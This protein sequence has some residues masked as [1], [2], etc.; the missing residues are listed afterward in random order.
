M[1]IFDHDITKGYDDGL[2]FRGFSNFTLTPG[3]IIRAIYSR[4]CRT[5]QEGQNWFIPSVY[6]VCWKGDNSSSNPNTR[7]PSLILPITT[8]DILSDHILLVVLLLCLFP[9]IA[10]ES[11]AHYHNQ[12]T[13]ILYRVLRIRALILLINE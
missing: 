12:S 2:P 1:V 4:D 9:V 11:G 13:T 3:R 6:S 7:S 8:I 5:T 10:E